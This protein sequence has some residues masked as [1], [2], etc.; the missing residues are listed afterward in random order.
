[1]KWAN[2]T[3]KRLI[4]M[5]VSLAMFMEAVDTNVIN[6]AIPVMSQS[7]HVNPINLKIALISYLLSLAI[8]IPI[9]GWIAD[10][11]GIKR[12]FLFA[13]AVFTISSF[14]CGMA[15]T[16]PE[17]ILARI[18]QGLGG[19]IMLPVARLIIVRNF[20]RHELI[21]TMNRVVMVGALGLMLGPVLGGFIVHYLSWRWIFWVNIPVG[22]AN[23]VMTYYAL[24]DEPPLPVPPLDKLGFIYFGT[25]L[26]AFTYSLSELSESTG[27]LSFALFVLGV[28]VLLL[29]AY[30][31]HSWKRPH[32]IVK[33][34]LFKARTFRTSAIG[35][36]ISRLGFAGVPFLV[37]LFLQIPLHYPAQIS[38]IVMAPMALGV[39]L[40]KPLTLPILRRVGYKKLLISNTLFVAIMLWTFYL[41]NAQS[42]LYLMGGMVFV[43]GFLL[44]MQYSA[45][46]SLAF[47]DIDQENLSAATS[48]MGTLQQLAQSFGVAVAALC[49]RIFSDDFA[50]LNIADFHYTFIAMGVL[51]LF[52]ALIFMR[53]KPE[54]GSA[55]L[56]GEKPAAVK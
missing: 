52:S 15:H 34:E 24:A 20:A 31:V 38:G 53:L 42:S 49:L 9:S 5:T 21:V 48:V 28:S 29:L 18:L 36:L 11:F 44:S 40:I 17:L 33:A 19:S 41:F 6:T 23:M 7:F 54:D 27:S 45:M 14:W 4:P 8:F 43:Y 26:S 39:L 2:V 16:L 47:A 32:Q 25:S 46:N 1:L 13:L 30:I 56:H 51:T 12:V 35:N 10:K 55:M 22:L 50:N 3:H 37:P